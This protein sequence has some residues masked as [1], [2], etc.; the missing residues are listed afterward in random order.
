MKKLSSFLFAL[1]LLGIVYAGPGNK[2]CNT[3]GSGSS[4]CTDA[5]SISFLFGLFSLSYENSVTCKEGEYACCNS[6]GA[7]CYP[8]LPNDV[9]PE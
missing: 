5:G 4:S 9:E 2:P 8:E 3:G 7:E 1:M 6:E